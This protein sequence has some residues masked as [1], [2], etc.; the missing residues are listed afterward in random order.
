MPL[1]N[2]FDDSAVLAALVDIDDHFHT[3]GRV[4]GTAAAP[5]GEVHVAD[6]D[7]M[8]AFQ[9]DAGNDTWGTWLQVVGSSDTPII[10]GSLHFDIPD[11]LI[12][13]VERN[14][15]IHRIQIAHGT[16]GAAALALGDYS[17]LIYKPQTTQGEETYVIFQSASISVGIKVWMR[18]WAAGQ[19]TGTLDAFLRIHEI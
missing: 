7:S 12:T 11:I 5:N 13:A 3:R 9:P 1:G 19:D 17:D 10:T 8:T 18:V 2:P 6:T 16:S 15:V 14:N 4:F